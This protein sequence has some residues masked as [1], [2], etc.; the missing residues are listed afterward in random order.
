MKID[1]DYKTTVSTRNS[2]CINVP[3]SMNK[4][5]P[6]LLFMT[7]AIRPPIPNGGLGRN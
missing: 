4:A 1:Q 3:V 7:G 2:I 6:T 5:N